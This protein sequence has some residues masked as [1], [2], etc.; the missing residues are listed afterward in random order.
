M[1]KIL[2]IFKYFADSVE[3]ESYRGDNFA[4]NNIYKIHSDYRG[5]KKQIGL[6]RAQAPVPLDTFNLFGA[7]DV[8]SNH[9]KSHRDD[10]AKRPD[11]L[12]VQN[13]ASRRMSFPWVP[14]VDSLKFDIPDLSAERL[15]IF[16]RPRAHSRNRTPN[17]AALHH[18]LP[19]LPAVH[20]KFFEL[21][22]A[23][24]EK[25]ESFYAERE[26]EMYER[27]KRLREQLN[28]LRIHREKFYESTA[29]SKSQGWVKKAHISLLAALLSLT[30]SGCCA[31]TDAADKNGILASES[32]RGGQ[33]NI[34]ILVTPAAEPIKLEESEHAAAEV[35]IFSPMSDSTS[36]GSAKPPKR[37]ATTSPRLFV[38]PKHA[39]DPQEYQYAKKRLKKAIVE[40]Y[41][42]LEVLNNYRILNFTGFRKA[43][44]KYEKIT[45]IPV[46]AAYMKERV[47]PAAFASG[48]MVSTML[49]EMEEIFATRFE[50]GDKKKAINR[51]RVGS[52][53]QSQHFSTFRSGL[54]LGLAVPA[55][56]A[57]SYMCRN[58]TLAAF[59]TC[60]F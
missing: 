30:G 44:K 10:E 9:K 24:I 43:L 38:A 49:K 21:L 4:L 17:P 13:Q 56:V 46:Q 12:I 2:L 1:P 25:I 32:G 7:T 39:L 57:G 55:V 23:E 3:Y 8:P 18:I 11:S 52:S 48:A 29:Q 28:E 45:K 47:E 59:A 16:G 60:F 42:G 37:G 22:D 41:R 51:L 40:H 14:S 54:W 35:R 53:L 27:G 20:V 34:S 15:P 33:V 36:S 50:R 19:H 26:K 58:S 5:L 31:E 6:I